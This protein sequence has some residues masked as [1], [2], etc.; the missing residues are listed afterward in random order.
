MSKMQRDTEIL[1]GRI[2]GLYTRPI[3]SNQVAL[4]SSTPPNPPAEGPT[5]E[6]DAFYAELYDKRVPPDM[7]E[8]A[9]GKERDKMK[10]LERQRDEARR[11]LATFRASSAEPG[12]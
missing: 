12:A 11:E 10:I 3:I 1:L 8:S 7:I 6:T 9:S 5:P 2:E 4:P